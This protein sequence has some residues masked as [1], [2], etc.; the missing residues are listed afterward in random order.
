VEFVKTQQPGLGENRFG[1]ER[2][3]VAIVDLA[4]RDVLPKAVDALMHVGHEFVKMRAALVGDRARLKKQVHQHGLAAADLAVNV[5]SARRL[6]LVGKQP[7]EQTLLA[8]RLVPRKPLL[9]RAQCLDRARLRGIGLDR[10]GGDEGL[11]VVA[12]RGGRG[13]TPPYG[14][15]RRKLQA[16]NYAEPCPGRGAAFFMPLRRAGTV[17][18]TGVRYGPG[19][20]VHRFA[21]LRAALRPGHGVHA[22]S[23]YESSTT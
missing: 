8:H 14:P 22:L 4:A 11:I 2:D 1:G 20:A 15:A 12:E 9:Q 7:A 6:V 16:A 18:S 17:P 19:S 10:A 13:M 21:V 3:D 23:V 5:K